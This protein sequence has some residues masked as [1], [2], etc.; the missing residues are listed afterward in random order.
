MKEDKKMINQKETQQERLKKLKIAL[1]SKKPGIGYLFSSIEIIPSENVTT[2]GISEDGKLYYNPQFIAKFSDTFVLSVLYHEILH[3]ALQHHYRGQ[4]KNPEVWNMATDLVINYEI[5]KEFNDPTFRKYGLYDPSVSG[6]SAEEVYKEL[7][8][9][10]EK[11]QSLQNQKGKK[12]EQ[13]QKEQGNSEQSKKESEELP[14]LGKKISEVDP[15]KEKQAGKLFENAQ[16][17]SKQRGNIPA[18]WDRW[19]DEIK[20]VY[21]DWRKFLYNQLTILNDM[22]W[23]DYLDDEERILWNRRVPAVDNKEGSK[24][25][26]V[27]DTSGSIGEGELSVFLGLI[28][29]Y[30]KTFSGSKFYV[31]GCDTE[32]TPPVEVD[33]FDIPKIKK[34]VK[35]GGG[36]DFRKAIEVAEKLNPDM[37]FYLTDLEGEFPKAVRK[38]LVWLSISKG[39]KAPIGKTVEVKI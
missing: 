7:L 15:V 8:N 25:V 26:F 3:F 16:N 11:Q 20:D 35:G 12:S 38:P 33:K 22:E 18:G 36:T 14:G 28:K 2:A 10:A 19:V 21:F 30:S 5:D 4:G 9:N 29:N 17:Y 39:K 37:I 23:K 34:A 1:L 24:V 6:K 13:Y 32:P 27:L 31:I